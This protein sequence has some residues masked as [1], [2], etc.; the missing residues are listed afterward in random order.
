MA[1]TGKSARNLGVV[2]VCLAVLAVNA[3]AIGCTLIRAKTEMQVVSDA[4][5]LRGTLTSPSSERRPIL[6]VLLEERA[7]R[8]TAAS[9][10]VHYG[11]GPF[12]LLARAGTGFIFAFED[13]NDDLHYQQGEPAAWY[14]GRSARP[15][16]MAPGGVVDGLDIVLQTTIPAGVDE[17]VEIASRGYEGNPELAYFRRGVAAELTDARFGPETGPLGLWEPVRFIT[18][19][20]MGLF[21][22]EAFDPAR[23]PVL[24]VHGAAGYPQE[25]DRLIAGLDRRRFQPW[26]YQYP[27]GLRLRLMGDALSSALDEVRT[28][29]RFHVLCIVGYSTGGLLA[30]AVINEQARRGAGAYVRLFVSISTPWDGHAAAAVGVQH[31]PVVVPSWVDIVEGSPYLSS[32]LAEPP[33]TSI[34]HHLYFSYRGGKGT[35]GTVSLRSQLN[36]RVQRGATRVLGFDED[37]ESM[38]GSAS[39]QEALNQALRTVTPRR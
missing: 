7:G 27:S 16:A 17:I 18:T 23:I 29:H 34:P 39:V 3:G 24:F 31:S 22:L 1:Q 14:G 37:H 8:K 5:T 4:T 2:A 38:L 25:F 26:V 35:D 11:S 9:Y 6:V 15:I 12:E 10:F 19:Y 28:R 21:F 32:L 30:R 33:P 20:G 13:T 36:P